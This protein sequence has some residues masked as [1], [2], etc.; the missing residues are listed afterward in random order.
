MKK[1]TSKVLLTSIMLILSLSVMAL[2]TGCGGTPTL[3]DYVN[4]NPKEQEAM[5]SELAKS[6]ATLAQSGMNA[7]IDI[8]ENQVI[9]TIKLDDMYKDQ[10][11]DAIKEYLEQYLE[12]GS[13]NF[14]T[15]A[16]TLEK[17]TKIEGVTIRV[18]CV[19]PDD[20]EICSKDYKPSK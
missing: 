6:N 15:L 9:Y 14:E 17:N 8:K 16:S 5:D 3:E 13:S 4:D 18:V 1:R 2:L 20:E 12:A 7:T 10:D 19:G 11:M